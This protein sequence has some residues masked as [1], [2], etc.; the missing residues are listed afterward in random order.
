MNKKL[1]ATDSMKNKLLEAKEKLLLT[2]KNIKMP[3]VK[4]SKASDKKSSFD[5]KAFQSKMNDFDW[6]SLKKYTSPQAAD[7]LNAFLEKLPQNAGQ[8]M[9]IMAGIS[10]CAAGAAGLFTTVQL[11]NLTELRVELEEAEA[12][13]PMVPKIVN[14]SANA[15][16]VK[17][18]VENAKELYKGLDI[19]AGGSAIS[20]SAKTTNAFGQFREA[21]GHI[22]SGGSG[23]KVEIQ[24]LCVGRECKNSQLSAS[25]KINT[26]SVKGA[27]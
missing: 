7:D 19:K 1:T 15:N 21:I 11:Q 6:R 17:E 22:Q 24:N 9:L 18:F 14:S 12:L 27:G 23:W 26:V 5:M 4:A 10:W 2:A 20:I 13:V 16:D 3:D 25:L 8:T